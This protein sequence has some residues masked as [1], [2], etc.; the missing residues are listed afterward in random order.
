MT[1]IQ[2]PQP[3][4]VADDVRELLKRL[5]FYG[6]NDRDAACAIIERQAIELEEWSS[7]LWA[8]ARQLNC[9]PSTYSDGNGHVLK[10]AIKL[11]TPLTDAQIEAGRDVTFS[12]NNPFCPC[13]SKTMRKAVRWAEHAHGI[14]DPS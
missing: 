13:D 9:L 4:P 14:K 2:S 1:E 8:V 3:A 6:D 7:T 5:R 12:T 11:T 10:A